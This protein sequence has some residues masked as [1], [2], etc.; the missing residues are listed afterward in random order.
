MEN[1][2]YI[3]VAF[4][5]RTR[6]TVIPLVDL[7]I[8]IQRAQ[9]IK[10]DLYRSYFVFGNDLL[11]HVKSTG[12]VANFAPAFASMDSIKLDIDRGT[13]TDESVYLKT[14]GAIL[15][16]Q[17]DWDLSDEDIRVFYSGSGYHIEIP[18]VFGF[19]QFPG[20]QMHTVKHTLNKH[21]KFA[22]DLY[23]P[24]SL[25]RVVN[26]INKKTNRYKRLLNMGVILHGK[27]EDVVSLASSVGDHFD[28]TPFAYTGK[29]H[30]EKIIHHAP[31]V[32][33]SIPSN[34]INVRSLEANRTVT[35]VQ[36][37]Y[38]EGP[39]P[40]S[41]HNMMMRMTSA[42][43]RGGVPR[44]AIIAMMQQWAP[45]MDKNDV[46]RLVGDIFDKGFRYGCND[47]LMSKF[48][49]PRCQHFKKKN[50]GMETSSASDMAASYKQYLKTVGNGRMLNLA[51]IYKMSKD[52][53]FLPGEYITVI[54]DSGI[55]KTAWVQNLAVAWKDCKILYLSLEVH[56][57]LLFRRFLQIAHGL[58]K[59]EVDEL[60][61]NSSDAIIAKMIEAIKHINV[62][63]VAPTLPTIEKMI[64]EERADLVIIDVIDALDV[65]ASNETEMTRIIARELKR[66]ANATSSIIIGIHHISKSAAIDENGKARQL[67]MHSAKGSSSIEQKGD[68]MIGIE[69]QGDTIRTVSSLKARDEPPFRNLPFKYDVDTFRFVQIENQIPGGLVIGS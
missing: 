62:A 66:I 54:G 15:E 8:A 25:Y 55:G 64:N 31:T 32:S 33:I 61:A 11:E 39:K 57:A 26:T 21:F 30:S 45:T 27:C 22:D 59:E 9:A 34:G 6:N 47:S 17:D 52:Y 4:G 29:V 16:L 42:F 12:S 14:R 43:R 23:Y 18:D 68:K 10:S 36:T 53:K 67:N 37:M 5:T 20:S 49:D 48:C 65:E 63:T 3:E 19:G 56:E 50:F 69:A 24:Q 35:C 13:D 7:P 46:A 40:G 60:L 38:N 41:R 51:D 1:T 58:K 44:A 28:H 2:A